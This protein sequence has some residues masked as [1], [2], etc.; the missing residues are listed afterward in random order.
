MRS[1]MTTGRRAMMLLGGAVLLW[2]AG[3]D[4][5]Y[6]CQDVEFDRREGLFSIPARFGVTSA[7]WVARAAGIDGR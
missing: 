6:A 2:V 3:F 4:V 7:L 1:T 5:L